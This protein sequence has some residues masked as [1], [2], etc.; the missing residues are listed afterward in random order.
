[1]IRQ[2]TLNFLTDGHLVGTEKTTLPTVLY[3]FC[4]FLIIKGDSIA[5]P[6]E[7]T[8]IPP[9]VAVVLILY[10]IFNNQIAITRNSEQ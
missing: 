2:D 3:Y 7:S 6:S 10:S 4:T 1:M 9:P 5:I 8:E